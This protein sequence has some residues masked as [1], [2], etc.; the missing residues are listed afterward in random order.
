MST[1]I[2]YK[3]DNTDTV[4]MQ[5][6]PR[7]LEVVSIKFINYILFILYILYIISNH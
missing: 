4:N 5:S 3:L 6:D 7:T 1:E 2:E